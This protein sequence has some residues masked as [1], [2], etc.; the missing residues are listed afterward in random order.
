MV[1][2]INVPCLFISFTT[3]LVRRYDLEWPMV[4]VGVGLLAVVHRGPASSVCLGVLLGEPAQIL[5]S[6]LP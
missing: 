3:P 2:N 1:H 5:C 6:T 4:E